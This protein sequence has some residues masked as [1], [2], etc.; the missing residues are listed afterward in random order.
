M[1]FIAHLSVKNKLEEKLIWMRN[2]E[3][4]IALVMVN[5]KNYY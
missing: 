2:L 3:E 1:L 5:L 4:V